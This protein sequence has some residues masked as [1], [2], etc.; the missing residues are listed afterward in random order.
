[1]IIVTFI[2]FSVQETGL[3]TTTTKNVT[4]VNKQTEMTTK[5]NKQQHQLFCLC[6]NPGIYFKTLMLFIF[7]KEETKVILSFCLKCFF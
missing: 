2:H 7:Q 4:K 1:M 3:T 6:W 5:I